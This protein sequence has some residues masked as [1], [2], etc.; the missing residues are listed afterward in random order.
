MKANADNEDK[1]KNPKMSDKSMFE[2]A[3]KV[4]ELERVCIECRSLRTELTVV[5]DALRESEST[6]QQL[7]IPRRL[8][9]IR[10]RLSAIVKALYRWKRTAASHVFVF[11][12]SSELRNKKPYAL[13]VQCVPCVSLK[14]SD[15]R[16]LTNKLIAEMVKRKMEVVGTTTCTCILIIMS[17]D[18]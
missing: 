17:I 16:Q 13:P 11:M 5:L 4:E 9:A 8:T 7:N 12:I 3:W 6:F 15:I 10:Q 1:L 14:E 18:Y 2:A